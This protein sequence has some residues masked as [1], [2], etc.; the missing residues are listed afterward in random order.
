MQLGPYRILRPLAEDSL[1]ATY[2]AME[3]D[4]QV[5]VRRLVPGLLV[6]P[7]V[8]ERLRAWATQLGGVPPPGLARVRGLLP[9]ADHY[10]LL[11]MQLPAGA[12][13]AELLVHR[14]TLAE[15]PGA[16]RASALPGA[17]VI[18][19]RLAAILAAAHSRGSYHLRLSPD[20]VFL[21]TSGEKETGLKVCLLELGLLSALAGSVLA[22]SSQSASSGIY[23]A[24]EQSGG[25]RSAVPVL[26]DGQSDVYALAVLLVQL[27]TGQTPER[28]E[29]PAAVA[30]LQGSA[31][32]AGLG[33]LLGAMLADEPQ[34][35]PSMA[36]VEAVLGRAARSP[37]SAPPLHAQLLAY[38]GT[39]A[40]PA[41]GVPPPGSPEVVV[42]TPSAGDPLLGDLVGNFRLVRKLGQGGMGVVYEAEHQQIG[43]RAAVKVLHNE[44]AHSPDYA[45]RFLNEARAVNII[46]HPSLVEIFEY[47]QR[48]DGSLYIVMEFLG[49]ESLY[50]RTGESGA[51]MAQT[52]VAELGLQIARALATAHEKGIIHRELSPHREPWLDFSAPSR[53]CGK[54]KRQR[55]Q[56]GWPALRSAPRPGASPSGMT[57]PIA[58]AAAGGRKTRKQAPPSIASM[59]SM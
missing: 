40:G 27:L 21:D 44:F 20:K 58:S 23:L 12:S 10:A 28:A 46:R 8:G 34:R 43:H 31:A 50:K 45:K 59:T 9:Q 25:S 26:G 3:G 5:V 16:N 56:H 55:S 33:S 57:A 38:Q 51:R 15:R 52:K 36:Q 18:A 1:G 24:P 39:L 48:T 7:R 29:W 47:G 17:L 2:L 54:S 6:D 11:V 32:P 19:L 4:E 22:T 35:R 41:D 14:S 13:L 49:G 42:T 37:E 30:Q 53:S